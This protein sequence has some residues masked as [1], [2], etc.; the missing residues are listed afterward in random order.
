MSF[1]E[2]VRQ[3]F[4]AQLEREDGNLRQ[5]ALKRNIAYPIIHK[6]KS[7]KSAFEKMSIQTLERLFP[8]MRVTLL[9]GEDAG[10]GV[11][12]RGANHGAIA[13]GHNAK[14]SINGVR[15]P[16]SPQTLQHPT[17]AIS[18]SSLESQILHA[19]DFSSD[20]R[21]KFLLFLKDKVK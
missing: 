6:L 18:R 13:N 15:L 3:T 2:Q 17:D 19:D 4:F 7:G 8:H 14:A 5:F 12:V 1:V 21:I 11:F 16:L 9:P 10:N 20:E